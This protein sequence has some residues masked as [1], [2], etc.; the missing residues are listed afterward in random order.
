VLCYLLVLLLEHAL[1]VE[2]MIESA[3]LGDAASGGPGG[4]DRARDR[5]SDGGS[6]GCGRG[7]RGSSRRRTRLVDQLVRLRPPVGAAW[8]L[9]VCDESTHA[10]F[11]H[12]HLSLR[13]P[14][15]ILPSQSNGSS[16]RDCSTLGVIDRL[17]AVLLVVVARYF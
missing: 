4:G 8:C 9:L 15:C 17:S 13:N 1:G 14:D 3:G 11:G 5:A 10:H 2:A 7:G 16:T 6:W 12:Q